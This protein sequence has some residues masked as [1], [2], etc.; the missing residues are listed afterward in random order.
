MTNKDIVQNMPV[1][2]PLGY[3]FTLLSKECIQIRASNTAAGS[4]NDRKQI[5]IMNKVPPQAPPDKSG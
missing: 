1:N 3:F 2:S 5:V 4:K